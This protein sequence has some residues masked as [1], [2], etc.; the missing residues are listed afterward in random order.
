MD[1]SAIAG[2]VVG[3]G[4]LTGAV[5]AAGDARLFFSTPAFLVTGGG[6]VA[7]VLVSYSLAGLITTIRTLVRCLFTV[8]CT[9]PEMNSTFARWAAIIRRD[10]MS[11]L[12]AEENEIRDPLLQHGL[13]MVLDQEET[14]REIEAHLSAQTARAMEQYSQSISVL[15]ALAAAAPAAGLVGTLIAVMQMLAALD[16]P[17]MIG[18]GLAAALLSTLYGVVIAHML[19]LPAAGWLEQR[20]AAAV[21]L[22][23]VT[24]D[25][26]L[27]MSD[28]QTPHPN[29]GG[30]LSFPGTHTHT[31][32]LRS[33]GQP[34]GSQIGKRNDMD[35]DR[36]GSSRRAA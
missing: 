7:V 3:A 34:A 27:A 15:R 25:G 17:A 13:K 32:G 33:A 29:D 12:E 6:A 20:A 5:Q 14:T 19:C 31:T 4:I 2:F 11:A 36:P 23:K 8:P 18:R 21:Q 10:G 26:L 9:L 16:D 22:H 30:L 28:G 35:K 24:I 1:K